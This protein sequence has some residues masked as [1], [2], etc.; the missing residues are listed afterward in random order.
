MKSLKLTLIAGMSALAL[1]ACSS[2][3][4]TETPAEDTTVVQDETSPPLALPKH[5]RARVH[6]PYLRQPTPPLPR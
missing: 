4:P 2:K 5:C 1:V 6:L 3:A